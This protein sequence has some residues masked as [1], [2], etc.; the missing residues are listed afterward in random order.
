MDMNNLK[1]CPFCGKPAHIEYVSMCGF[2]VSIEGGCQDEEC[3]GHLAIL[4]PEPDGEVD[5]RIQVAVDRWN[6]RV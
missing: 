6:R 2:Y 5:T 4:V 3:P 1:P